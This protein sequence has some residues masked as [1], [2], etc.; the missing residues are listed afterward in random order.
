MSGATYAP[1]EGPT[2][3]VS[4]SVHEGT[5]QAVRARVGKR[6]VSPYVEAAI[7]RQ[8]ERDNLAELIE[9]YEARHGEITEKEL[10]AAEEKVFG[11][12]DRGGAGR[13]EAAA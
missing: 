10:K 7:Q 8:I 11:P 9:D 4:V 1:G 3:S 12:T 6:G 5:I 13:P 2:K